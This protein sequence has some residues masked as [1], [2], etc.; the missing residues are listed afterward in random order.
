MILFGCGF[1]GYRNKAFFEYDL[2]ILR[3]GEHWLLAF[4]FLLP[5]LMLLTCMVALLWKARHDDETA[6]FY[7]FCLFL[8]SFSP[9]SYCFLW[10][11]YVNN[12]LNDYLDWLSWG[13]FVVIAL[14]VLPVVY[15]TYLIMWKPE[16]PSPDLKVSD[17][18]HWGEFCRDLQKNKAAAAAAGTDRFSLL[19][20]FS[21]Q[22]LVTAIQTENLR[23]NRRAEVIEELNVL[24]ATDDLDGAKDFD[25]WVRPDKDGYETQMY[26]RLLFDQAYARTM[27][28]KGKWDEAKR[29][30]GTW[31]D[32]KRNRLKNGLAKS[33]FW[34]TVFFFTIFLGI[35]YLLGFAFAFH[36]QANLR[37]DRPPALF[38]PRSPLY[39]VG[40]YY[41]ASASAERK[42]GQSRGAGAPV[43][44]KRADKPDDSSWPEYVFY[45]D[46]PYAAFRHTGQ[47]DLPT[48]NQ[49]FCQKSRDAGAAG[50]KRDS[51]CAGVPEEPAKKKLPPGELN[52]KLNELHE[53][54]KWSKNE[55]R[56]AR[57]VKAIELE[58]TARHG[59]GLQI[60]VRGGADEKRLDAK[61]RPGVSYPSNYTLSEARAQALE[62]VLLRMLA[63]TG[64]LPGH[65]QWAIIP[66]SNEDPTIP[67]SPE[68]AEAEK[69]KGNPTV[70]EKI[71]N[72]G[73]RINA[74][75]TDQRDKLML[76][77]KRITEDL[78][79]KLSEKDKD[80]L[81]TKLEL[82][83]ALNLAPNKP[84]QEEQAAQRERRQQATDSLSEAVEAIQYEHTDKDAAK[85][86]VVVSI[87]PVQPSQGH[88]FAP[89]SLMDYMYFTIYT[90]TTTGYGDIVPTT[91]YAKFLCSS[92]NILEV[93]F[94]VVFFNGLLSMRR[95]RAEVFE[96]GAAR[97][98]AP[99][100]GSNLGG[101][102][103]ADVNGGDD[104]ANLEQ[105]QTTLNEIKDRVEKM[106]P[107]WPISRRR[108]WH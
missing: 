91:T 12:A 39:N 54:W 65:F 45:F 55:L 8:M 30:A 36:D 81:L 60:L 1:I 80:E 72:E 7:S 46:T 5:I 102:T 67:L 35:T 17:I 56:L 98:P 15:T 50:G 57:L 20:R 16:Q 68:K 38:S 88:M 86:V 49:L 63:D 94:F 62:Y 53:E 75:Q 73:A 107:W 21:K 22:E 100:S 40:N 41:T 28:P 3:E 13:S 66:M 83:I 97:L 58:D 19:G 70:D 4:L 90:I 85:R 18:K 52:R 76:Q 29:K 26:N 24:F 51:T 59:Q 27:R 74:I 34:A 108:R 77:F 92:A 64:E 87:K 99:P 84:T 25:G 42:A 93:F 89:L 44:S 96:D 106:K 10:A 103:R 6:M 48:F 78:K 14:L 95:S 2:N 47:F 11:V 82:A 61:E 9:C 43:T 32:L 71:N 31:Y 33:P 23:P 101:A 37:T 105:I 69:Q 79:G 104:K